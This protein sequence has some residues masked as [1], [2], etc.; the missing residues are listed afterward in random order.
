MNTQEL[1]KRLP[2]L[3]S[4]SL[5]RTRSNVLRQL[6]SGGNEGELL[7]LRNALDAE[8]MGRVELPLD[9]W[10][11]GRQGEPRFFMR[12][13]AKL[14]VVIRSETHGATKGAYHIEVLGVALRDRPRN[15]DVARDLAEA[16]LAEREDSQ[17]T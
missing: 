13:G 17:N 12:G 1:I 3:S 14:A 6:E 15:V 11:S 8:L 9:G 2:D 4:P 16:A 5:I 7:E 10:S